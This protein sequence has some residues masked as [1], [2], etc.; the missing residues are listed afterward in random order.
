MPPWPGTGTRSTPTT[1]RIGGIRASRLRATS[2]W[3]WDAS[4]P[5]SAAATATGRTRR[6]KRSSPPPQLPVVDAAQVVD[7]GESLLAEELLGHRRARALGAV[8]DH[9]GGGRPQ[10]AHPLGEKLER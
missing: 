3:G 9:R 6:R 10:L 4:A 8:H 1:A 2:A 7:L 5:A